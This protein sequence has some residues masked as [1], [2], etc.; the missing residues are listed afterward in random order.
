MLLASKSS[1][2]SNTPASN[3]VRKP[4]ESTD[5]ITPAPNVVPH[6]GN[7]M[8]QEGIQLSAQPIVTDLPI[9]R[10]A[11]LTRFLEKRKDRINS[12]A[13]Y[14]ISDSTAVPLSKPAERRSWIGLAA[15]SPLHVQP[16]F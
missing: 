9:K 16:H 13:P 3:L 6:F 1:Q 12:K 10:K 15:Q 2:D 14:Q 5:L 11:S 7:N 8:V 4:G